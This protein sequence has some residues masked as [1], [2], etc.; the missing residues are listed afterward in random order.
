[1][2]GRRPLV[3]VSG[4]PQELGNSDYLKFPSATGSAPTGE[5][6]GGWDSDD[7]VL[8]IGDGAATKIFRPDPGASTSYAPIVGGITIGNGSV[9]AR[10]QLIAE[11][12]LWI[13]IR[14]T[15]GST[16]SFTGDF[17]FTLPFN[18]AA[19]PGRQTLSAIYV[20]EGTR[21]HVGAGIVSAS[22]SGVALIN[23][24]SGNA[25]LVNSTRPFAWSGV[26]ADKIECS[27]V[28]SIA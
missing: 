10:F 17:S 2:A 23:A 9:D 18:A 5:G 4:V 3:V 28:V 13:G 11:K 25:G 20:D 21:F 8:K 26:N 14:I 19:N 24:E 6:E 1:M 12:L 15:L 16:S 22:A 7:D 27:G